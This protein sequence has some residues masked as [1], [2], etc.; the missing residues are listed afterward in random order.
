MNIT[1]KARPRSGN[2]VNRVWPIVTILL[3]VQSLFCLRDSD[4][5]ESKNFLWKVRSKTNTVYLLGSV[6]LS[7][8]EMY[9]LNKR[10]EEAFQQS[11]F[12]AVE[13]N[14]NGPV[15]LDLQKVIEKAVYSDREDTLETHVS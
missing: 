9:P 15:Q 2:R 1:L 14:L 7:K 4:A 6:H 3:L 5:A 12:L 11:D 8:K 13:A 10:I